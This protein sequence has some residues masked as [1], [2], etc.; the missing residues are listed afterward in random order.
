MSSD[1]LDSTAVDIDK[2]T[3]HVRSLS[4]QRLYPLQEEN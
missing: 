2:D 3:I 4:I 1:K